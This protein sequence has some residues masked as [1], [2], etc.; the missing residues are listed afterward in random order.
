[1]QPATS[2]PSSPAPL[3]PGESRHVAAD[4]VVLAD[5]PLRPG[6]AATT[7]FGDDVWDLT[8]GHLAAAR[9]RVC[10]HLERL[11]D[12]ESRVAVK[13]L[14]YMRLRT[15][16]SAKQPAWTVGAAAA[17]AGRLLT[18]ATALREQHGATLLTVTPPQLDAWLRAERERGVDPRT[19][20]THI[21]ALRLLHI[22]R[23]RLT[24]ALPYLPWGRRASTLVAGATDN[25]P[26]NTTPRIPEA[27]VGPLVQWALRYV[28]DYGPEICR[29]VVDER[30]VVPGVAADQPRHE[31][32]ARLV[33]WL[34]AEGR[35]FWARTRYDTENYSPLHDRLPTP[36]GEPPLVVRALLRALAMPEAAGAARRLANDEAAVRVLRDGLRELGTDV[37][38]SRRERRGALAV[39][40]GAGLVGRVLDHA[41]IHL[42]TAC[43]V[44]VAYLSGMRDSELH[45]LRADCDR[46]QRD[47]DGVVVRYKVAGRVYKGRAPGGDEATWVVVEPVHRA[48]ATLAGLRHAL[49]MPADGPLLFDTQRRGRDNRN[50]RAKRMADRLNEFVAR[51]NEL[52]AGGGETPPSIP[53]HQ[54]ARWHLTTRQFRRTLAWYIANRPFGTVA[55]AIQYKHV[56]VGIFE[57]YGGTS[58][59][60]FGSEVW[61]EKELA[62]LG[63][64]ENM[65]EDFERGVDPVGPHAPQLRQ[66]FEAVRAEAFRFAGRV[67]ADDDRVRDLLRQKGKH[68]HVGLLNDC[69]FDPAKAMCLRRDATAPTAPDASAPRF[70][71]CRP[72]VC[73]NS[74]LRA[75]H[76]P[77]WDR[78]RGDIRRRREQAGPKVSPAQAAIW[79][80]EEARITTLIAPY[81]AN[82]H[83]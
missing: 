67:L 20:A 45:S 11:V 64:L 22:H 56:E 21:A 1:V 82:A 59:S 73:S 15:R 72:G 39:A 12:P 13:D 49:G 41:I 14:I 6:A 74:I 25:N 60:G 51:C 7:R 28:D 61:A 19:T 9:K 16:V 69:H 40:A 48:I 70:S 31:R 53:R 26:E 4:A 32:A 23:A 10:V 77:A 78:A 18:L 80:A 66:V 47:A 58:E 17:A 33:A 27:V 62:N 8:A 65:Y 75:E 81:E 37:G 83:A 68:L 36:E 29:A 24:F 79:D 63:L 35:G 54:G 44:V 42:V 3:A 57:G 38:R 50:L 71:L 2:E 43:Y 30:A 55:G 34:R 5:L 76:V 52:A 46:V